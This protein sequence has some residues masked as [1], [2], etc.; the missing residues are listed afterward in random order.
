MS[1]IEDIDNEIA[2]LKAEL[3]DTLQAN[4]IVLTS[5]RDKAA[6]KASQQEGL[7]TINAQYA[8]LI[9]DLEKQK[10]NPEIVHVAQQAEQTVSQT[11]SFI[12]SNS[13]L[14]FIGLLGL[15]LVILGSGGKKK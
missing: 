10:L 2:R 5:S 3:A 9:S 1:F 12:S 8:K 14:F 11:A 15:G 4:R 6:S 13:L 7:N